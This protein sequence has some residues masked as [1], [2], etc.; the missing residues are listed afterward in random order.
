MI[1]LSPLPAKLD[2]VEDLNAQRMSRDCRNKRY[3]PTTCV[4][5][6]LTLWCLRSFKNSVFFVLFFTTPPMH[7]LKDFFMK[8][9]L[10]IVCTIF[11]VHR[12]RLFMNAD[13]VWAYLWTHFSCLF[14]NSIV[15]RPDLCSMCILFVWNVNLCTGCLV[16]LSHLG[17]VCSNSYSLLV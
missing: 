11:K 12:I 8:M 17:G 4:D 15:Y 16:H 1:W 7:K 6:P 3:I 10:D 13:E 14:E 5:H 2:D 9:R